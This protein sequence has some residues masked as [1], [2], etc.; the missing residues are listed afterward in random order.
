MTTIN[1]SDDL[2]TVGR[3]RTRYVNE[4]LKSALSERARPGQKRKLSG[5]QEAHLVAIACSDPPERT[6]TA[7]A[8]GVVHPQSE[9]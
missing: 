4:G 1:T 2:S 7:E 6:Q 9:R 5:K 3:I 8:Q